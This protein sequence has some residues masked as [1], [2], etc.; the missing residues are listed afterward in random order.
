M[1]EYFEII[2][3]S[4]PHIYHSA[5]VLTPKTSVIWKLYGSH[6]RP[7]TRIVRGEPVSWDPATATTLCSFV[8]KLAVWS[9]CTKFIAISPGDTMTMDILNSANLW[10]LRGL[11]FPQETSAHPESLVF[12]SNSL[13]LTCSGHRNVNSGQ[14]LLIVSW[15]LQTGEVVSVIKRPGPDGD[16]TVTS[17]VV[18]SANGKLVGIL[19]RCGAAATISIYDVISGT[20][21]YD[22][23]YRADMDTHLPHHLHLCDIWTHGE[24]LRL[25]TVGP[26]TITI[27]EVEFSPGTTPKTVETLPAPND[28]IGLEPEKGGIIHTQ[29][30]APSC[31]L[32][33]SRAR[34]AVEVL[35]WD[36]RNS[37][38]LLHHTDNS[39]PGLKPPPDHLSGRNPRMSFSSDGRFFAFSTTRSEVCLWQDSSSGYILD[40]R[41]SPSSVKPNPLLSPNGELIIA[42]GGSMI[43]LWRTKSY[44]SSSSRILTRGPEHTQDFALEFFPDRPLA[45]V[46]RRR[47]N[48]LTVLDLKSGAPRLTID[49]R[50]EVYGLKV[51]DNTI[52]AIGC[53]KIITWNLPE[54]DSFRY[55]RM[56]VEDCSHTRDFEVGFPLDNTV[57]TSVSLDLRYVA[58]LGDTHVGERFLYIRST[59]TEEILD[60]V[61]VD[62]VT[63]WIAPGG[64]DIWCG[65]ESEAEVFTV[66]SSGNLA[67]KM[68]AVDI[69]GGS[70]RCPW[71]SPRGYEVTNEGWIL[72]PSGKRLFMLLP[73]WQSLPVQRVWNGRFLALLHGSLPEPVIL[74]LGP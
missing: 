67:R 36:A 48:V 71:G 30:L 1:T 65:V 66:T 69:E 19:H 50:I 15:D 37:K 68:S 55:T 27:R 56:G 52:V 62:G 32:A 34:G 6:A 16:P 8:I 57:A 29:F 73:P 74:E 53:G 11:K 35:V 51:I 64:Q 25:A 70:W 61:R 46:I 2:D 18:Y 38:Y 40:G 7:F 49:A 45:A 12:S 20:Y 63:M 9:P 10:R 14:E 3:A 44:T 59:S 31:L 33:F 43:Q 13:M 42:F 26:T 17:R 39:S 24:S 47:Q 58:L 23:D 4:P 28:K 21:V 60:R 22:V 5:L 72:G 41:L 54:G